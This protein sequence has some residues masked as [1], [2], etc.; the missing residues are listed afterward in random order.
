MKSNCYLIRFLSSFGMLVVFWSVKQRFLG[1]VCWVFIDNVLYEPNMYNQLQK[2]NS[3]ISVYKICIFT[4]LTIRTQSLITE[5]LHC[6]T[7]NCVVWFWVIERNNLNKR[8]VYFKNRVKCKSV[9][10]ECSN[11]GGY[12]NELQTTEIEMIMNTTNLY[13]FLV[14]IHCLTIHN[15]SI[16][17]K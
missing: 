6:K 14:T 1:D 16:I 13:L 4:F 3:L 11:V 8:K 17:A 9:T 15:T 5:D 7:G 10:I 12:Y 2:A